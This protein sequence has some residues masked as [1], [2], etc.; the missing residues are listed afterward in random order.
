MYV[1]AAERLWGQ[2]EDW[3]LAVRWKGLCLGCLVAFA[4]L[5]V[6]AAAMAT[7][8]VD[9]ESPPVN[10][11]TPVTNQFSAQGVT[12]TQ[13]APTGALSTPVM[14]TSAT[15]HSGTRVA[16][17]SL[18]QNVEFPVPSLGG[19]FAT[20]RRSV[21]IWVRNVTSGSFTAHLTLQGL[22]SSGTVVAQSN[23]GAPTSVSSVGEPWVQ[24]SMTSAG[25]D[26]ASFTI[27]ADSALD[28]GD[29][30]QV[31][32]LSFDDPVSAPPPGIQ[33]GAQHPLVDMAQGSSTTVPIDVGR[34]NG[35]NGPVTLSTGGLP[36]GVTASFSPNPVT[37]SGASSTLTLTASD[38]AQGAVRF[39]VTVTGTPGGG[40]GTTTSSVQVTLTVESAF[41]I[42]A[43]PSAVQSIQPCS[44]LTVT[45]N[46]HRG[47]G[48][49]A[50]VDITAGNAEGGG[51]PDLTTAVSAATLSG[52]TQQSTVTVNRGDSPNA[53]DVSLLVAARSGAAFYQ[54]QVPIDR[55]NPTISS[56]GAFPGPGLLA[57]APQGLLGGDAGF[58]TG[59]GICPG[60]SVEWGSPD[61]MP[62][63]G[64]DAFRSL[65]VAP[66][67][68]VA[69][70]RWRFTIPRLAAPGPVTVVNPG[71]GTAS[72]LQSLDVA[73]Y[74]NTNGFS[75]PNEAWSGGSFD[76]WHALF[77][78]QLY[79]S[80]NPCFPL[81][82]CTIATLPVI[83]PDAAILIPIFNAALAG[84]GG[85]CVGFSI[86]SRR[87][88]T[89][90][91]PLSRFAPHVSAVNG[92]PRTDAL[93]HYLH[94]QHEN[95]LSA[96]FINAYWTQR[97]GGLAGTRSAGD[98]RNDI[99][100]ELRLGRR[101]V[102]VMAD[103]GQG[104]A[105]IAYDVESDSA[106]PG[107]YFIRVYDNNTPSP[108]G[109]EATSYPDRR[110]GEQGSRIH[111]GAGG[112][113]HFP[114]LNWSGGMADIV[115]MT[116][117][118]DIPVQPSWPLSADGL[119]IAIFGAGAP[120][121]GAAAA[122]KPA[123]VTPFPTLDQGRHPRPMY[124]VSATR[125]VS[126][127][128]LAGGDGATNLVFAG[129]G[130]VARLLVNSAPGA[131]G[132]VSFPGGQTGIGYASSRTGRLDVALVARGAGGASH[133]AEVRSSGSGADTFS[134]DR[135]GNTLN[136]VHRGAP[137]SI[138]MTLSSYGHV[139][140]STFVSPPVRLGAAESLS[141]GGWSGFGGTLAVT[142]RGRG[143]T[144]RLVL[145]NRSQ[146]NLR[147]VGATAQRVGRTVTF[148]LRIGLRSGSSRR[149]Q[150]AAVIL[151]G[152]RTVARRVLA[153][154]APRNGK[155]TLAITLPRSIGPRTR[156]RAAVA[157]VLATPIGLPAER[158]T[159]VTV[160]AQHG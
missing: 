116:A 147:T 96:E 133:F 142:V 144:H 18:G 4:M 76:D 150:V 108:N 71:G 157:V 124:L 64:G 152:R 146:A 59:T 63:A 29:D 33:L 19:E 131:H 72:S 132:T 89:G 101:P 85:T 115:E 44:S 153:V 20:T 160:S 129:A 34:L 62:P 118:H 55:P 143:G 159:V 22:N 15:A 88:A 98:L 58:V 35:S 1:A 67:T 138:T 136:V 156:L 110:N 3:E 17:I 2:H 6:P 8:T 93:I 120:A 80:V 95:Q 21:S 81:F 92:L 60:A 91:V 140:P 37:G 126:L 87:L 12:F 128:T 102:I 78:D 11:N 158:T 86:G 10:D 94:I 68:A 125:S 49:S 69:P 13:G 46:L 9:F 149:L 83:R 106:Q 16:D 43:S 32:D 75:F 107:A 24:L 104:H 84:S 103:G 79:I 56:I 121:P 31:D 141:V 139:L 105:V 42:T 52:S 74:R 47:P 73:T 36:V 30:V 39:P 40:A 48:F 25:E 109:D 155:V 82:D 111:V 65:A 100:R 135:A 54:V 119:R 134:F 57:R 122:A 113:W 148:A 117:E 151:A 53:A 90:Q 14:A 154:R 123:T 28:Q 137:T 99:E 50:P 145:A 45:I 97:T 70:G 77:G 23:G 112:E 38:T 41:T 66:L 61:P 127:G 26:I 5:V 51:F 114:N 7:T 130:G 27:V